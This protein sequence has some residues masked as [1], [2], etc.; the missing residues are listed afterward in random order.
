MN[1]FE[2]SKVGHKQV[3]MV[4]VYVVFYCLFNNG[5]LFYMHKELCWDKCSQV[6]FR[7]KNNIALY[8]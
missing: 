7:K 5:L 1:S 3:N 8:A 4:S 2:N 6:L